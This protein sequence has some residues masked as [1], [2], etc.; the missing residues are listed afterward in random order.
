MRVSAQPDLGRPF[1]R[2]GTKASRVTGA[3][4]AGS[5]IPKN[6]AAS[7]T[8]GAVQGQPVS[9]HEFCLDGDMGMNEA[10]AI[11]RTNASTIRRIGPSG[12]KSW[13]IR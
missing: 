1:R 9:R 5:G 7:W 13:T 4:L 10:S 2:S 6:H 8:S 12:E 3:S 11:P